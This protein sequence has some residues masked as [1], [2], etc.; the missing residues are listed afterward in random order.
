MP[1]LMPPV[2][3]RT[4]GEIVTV[5]PI[6]TAK[7]PDEKATLLKDLQAWRGKEF[8]PEELDGFSLEVLLGKFC[9]VNI[10]HSDYNDKTYAN[11]SS[12]SQVPAALKKSHQAFSSSSVGSFV[13]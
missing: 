1:N 4:S 2:T 8:T 3:L 12:V 13:K 10:T 6:S 5:R 9:M 7:L 11:I